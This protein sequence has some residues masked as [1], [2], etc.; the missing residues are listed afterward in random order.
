M[1][2][3]RTGGYAFPMLPRPVPPHAVKVELVGGVEDIDVGVVGATGERGR[4][5]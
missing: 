5:T 2:R 3:R 4:G 1:L